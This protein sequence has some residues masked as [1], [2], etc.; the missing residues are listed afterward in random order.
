MP[1]Y[2]VIGDSYNCI[3]CGKKSIVLY[4]KPLITK[5]CNVGPLGVE[6]IQNELIQK[7]GVCESCYREKYN[8]PEGEAETLHMIKQEGVC[9]RNVN[10]IQCE[11]FTQPDAKK[12]YYRYKRLAEQLSEQLKG[13]KAF[14]EVNVNGEKFYLI[15]E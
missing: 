5:I 1:H 14:E 2:Q 13:R 11:N 10:N 6:E 8:D 15:V 4:D 9:W 3:E 7:Q 12:K